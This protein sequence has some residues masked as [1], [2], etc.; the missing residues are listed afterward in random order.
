MS[1]DK[2]TGDVTITN[3]Q[4]EQMKKKKKIIKNFD[5]VTQMRKDLFKEVE[6]EENFEESDPNYTEAQMA[7]KYEA[8]RETTFTEEHEFDPEMFY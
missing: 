8:I 5:E 3:R 2:A 7:N 1:Y 6:L 4:K